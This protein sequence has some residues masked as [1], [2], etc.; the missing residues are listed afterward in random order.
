[1]LIDRFAANPRASL[2]RVVASDAPLWLLDEPLNGLDEDGLAQ[3]GT[4]VETHRKGGGAVLVASHRPMR[5]SWQEL[6]L[7]A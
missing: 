5:G 7:G 4:L 1:M 2:A 3:L 6:R